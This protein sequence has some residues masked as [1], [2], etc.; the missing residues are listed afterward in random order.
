[1]LGLVSAILG[2]LTSFLPNLIAYYQIKQKQEYELELI[3]LRM[4]AADQGLDPSVITASVTSVVEEG[5]NLRYHDSII[6][7]NKYINILRASVRPVLTYLF[8]FLFVGVKTAAASLM[9]QKGYGG[10]QVLEVVWDSYTVSIFG[11]IM[12]YWF[13]TRSMVYVSENLNK[14]NLESKVSTKEK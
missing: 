1:M 5:E 13:G 11:A 9:F 6:S 12:G 14:G 2:F 4:A 3:K 10:L 8:F 7:N